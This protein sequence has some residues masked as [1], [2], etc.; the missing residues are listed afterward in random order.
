MFWGKQGSG[1]LCET[2]EALPDAPHLDGWR[3]GEPCIW[4]GARVTAGELQPSRTLL[5]TVPPAEAE[6]TTARQVNAR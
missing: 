3:I 6:K 1:S 5:V 2:S 4:R